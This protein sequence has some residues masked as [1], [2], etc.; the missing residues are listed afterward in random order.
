MDIPIPRKPVI[1]SSWFSK[2]T[3]CFFAGIV[4][5]NILLATISLLP[6]TTLIKLGQP[7]IAILLLGQ[8]ALGMALGIGFSIP[9]YK[10]ERKN[11]VDS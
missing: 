4:P 1:P 6:R 5:V 2:F 10:R 7:F 8:F 3:E 11:R 9:W